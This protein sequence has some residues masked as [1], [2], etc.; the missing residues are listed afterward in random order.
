VFLSSLLNQQ[1]FKRD[2]SMQLFQEQDN[3]QDDELGKKHK[4]TVDKERKETNK[5]I[6]E[7]IQ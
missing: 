7:N 3:L 5:R 1:V 6:T 4:Y 2:V